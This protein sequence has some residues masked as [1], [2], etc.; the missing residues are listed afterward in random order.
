MGGYKFTLDEWDALAERLKAM[1][2]Q[3]ERKPVNRNTQ[4]SQIQIL[5]EG[6]RL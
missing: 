1:A 4:R 5:N 3:N 6:I 2:S